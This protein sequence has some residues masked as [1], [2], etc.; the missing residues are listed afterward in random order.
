MSKLCNDVHARR[1]SVNIIWFTLEFEMVWATM[2]VL[3]VKYHEG[4]LAISLPIELLFQIASLDFH[5][6]IP[7]PIFNI[8][9]IFFVTV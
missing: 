8:F 9:I 4:V 7:I 3:R 5:T 1:I 6:F 2:G